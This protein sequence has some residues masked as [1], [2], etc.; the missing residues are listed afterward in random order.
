MPVHRGLHQ[1]GVHL[2]RLVLLVRPR[3]Q[4]EL[5][6]LL[7][8]LFPAPADPFPLDPLTVVH[9]IVVV[10]HIAVVV[11]L[12]TVAVLEVAR[13]IV[14]L[15]VARHIV[16]LELD[17]RL[18]ALVGARRIGVVLQQVDDIGVG[19]V[20]GRR[21]GAVALAEHNRLKKRIPIL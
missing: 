3:L 9:R 14:V 19:L 16:V 20:E 13:R 6:H 7:F 12:R 2:V 8:L 17:D 5:D 10:L 4:Q 15:E 1:R 11:L 18:V 21:I